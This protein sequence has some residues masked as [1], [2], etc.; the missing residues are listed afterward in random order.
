MASAEMSDAKSRGTDHLVPV[1][2]ITTLVAACATPENRKNET[3]VTV[4]IAVSAF[5]IR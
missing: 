5:F 2:I 3:N 4:K 1:V